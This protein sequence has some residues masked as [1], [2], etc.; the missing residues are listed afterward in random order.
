MR[1]NCNHPDR[2]KLETFVTEIEARLVNTRDN[3]EYL[4]DAYNWAQWPE[5]VR[6]IHRVWP[7]YRQ[8]WLRDQIRAVFHLDPQQ[9]T[10]VIGRIAGGNT[11]AKRKR[12]WAFARR[13]GLWQL[14]RANRLLDATKMRRLISQ[15]PAGKDFIPSEHVE[16]VVDQMAQAG[17]NVKAS[18]G[19]TR[20]D[21]RK[22]YFKLQR[23]NQVLREENIA[24]KAEIAVLRKVMED[25]GLKPTKKTSNKN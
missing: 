24:L 6:A 1:N 12:A 7:D 22:E 21:Y 17:Q 2:F 3:L 5:N 4:I 11:K 25:A 13:V 16:N 8:E 10:L 19:P 14:I 18:S 20:M 23:E 15:F 9:A